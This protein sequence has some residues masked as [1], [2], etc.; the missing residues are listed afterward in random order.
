MLSDGRIVPTLG[1]MARDR[2]LGA[3]TY[4]AR[5]AYEWASSQTASGAVVQ[6]KRKVGLG[7]PSEQAIRQ[8]RQGAGSDLLGRLGDEHQRALPLILEADQCLG[9]SDPACHVNVVAAAMGDEGLAAVPG[10]LVVTRIRQARLFLHR[11]SIEFGAHHDGGAVAVPVDRDQ[12]RLADPLGDLE[13]ERTHFSGE[14]CRRLH[15]PK[16]NFRMGVDV[17]VECVELWVVDFD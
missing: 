7:K 9:R 8:H 1:W 6:A 17:L 4:A 13:A 16:G 2:N 11:Q 15:L 5:A 10:G 12:P 14:I 3:R